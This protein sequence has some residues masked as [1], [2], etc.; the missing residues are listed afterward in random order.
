MD[1]DHAAGTPRS[2]SPVPRVV[3]SRWRSEAPHRHTRTGSLISSPLSTPNEAVASP[4]KRYVWFTFVRQ[5][6]RA[7]APC[8]CTTLCTF[9]RRANACWGRAP[10]AKAIRGND[11]R[12]MI[13]IAEPS[14]C[15][16]PVP[17]RRAAALQSTVLTRGERYAQRDRKMFVFY[18]RR[19]GIITR[20]RVELRM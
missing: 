13:V 11:A 17:H 7:R 16:E 9:V 3:C 4:P 18:I 1:Y 20:C 6:P 2:F 12:A 10:G 8:N 5:A 15:C 14:L 19:S